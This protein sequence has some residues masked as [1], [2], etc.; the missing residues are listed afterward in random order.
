MTARHRRDGFDG[1]EATTSDAQRLLDHADVAS[2]ASRERD[3]SAVTPSPRRLPLIAGDWAS[4]CGATSMAAVGAP[5]V[6]GVDGA[7]RD[8]VDAVRATTRRHRGRAGE[9]TPS[10]RDA[11]REPSDVIEQQH[12]LQTTTRLRPGRARRRRADLRALHGQGAARDKAQRA[13]PSSARAPRPN[14]RVKEPDAMRLRDD[15]DWWFVLRAGGADSASGWTRSTGRV[16]PRRR[17]ITQKTHKKTRRRTSGTRRSRASSKNG[18][19]ILTSVTRSNLRPL[20]TI[21]FFASGA[22]GDGLQT[23]LAKIK[24]YLL[25]VQLRERAWPSST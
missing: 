6:D 16:A 19:R 12:R 4:F 18:S 24:A 5:T 8:A 1:V 11:K 10:T 22:Q 25:Q 9:R 2:M 23:L 20:V 14:W 21:A 7:A 15:G 13:R 3:L 17:R